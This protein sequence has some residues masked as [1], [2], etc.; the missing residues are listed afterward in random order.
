MTH[1]EVV[2][3]ARSKLEGCKGSAMWS[4]AVVCACDAEAL[5]A[6]GKFG[7]DRSARNRAIKSLCYSIGVF[8]P[9]YQAALRK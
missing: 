6:T 1:A 8:D 9:D 3:L 5:I 7:D 2:K 4:S